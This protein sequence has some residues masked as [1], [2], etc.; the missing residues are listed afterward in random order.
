[1][2]DS[3]SLSVL[4]LLQLADSALPIGSMAHSFGLETLV[5]DEDIETNVA[6]LSLCR[7]RR[8]LEDLPLRVLAGR[9]RVLPRSPFAR[10]ATVRRSSI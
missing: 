5:F 4:Q 10:A 2:P 7:S 9:R 3:S 1:M 6:K 8:Y